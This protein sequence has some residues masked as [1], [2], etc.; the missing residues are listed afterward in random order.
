MMDYAK[1]NNC[2]LWIHP[3]QNERQWSVNDSWS[4]ILDNLGGDRLRV[5]INEVL[6]AFIGKTNSEMLPAPS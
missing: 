3:W 2:I 5:A 6:A 1:S 4:C